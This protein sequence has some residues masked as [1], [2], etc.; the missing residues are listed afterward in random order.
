MSE[1]KTITSMSPEQQLN[2]MLVLAT[3]R[4]DGQ[5]D[6]GGWP[7]ILHC[8]KVM[9][10][11]RTRDFLLMSIAVGHD[12]FEDTDTTAEELRQ[13]GFDER[14]IRGIEALTKIPGQ[15]NREYLERVKANPDAIRVKL[16]DLRH[17]SDIRR[18]KGVTEKDLR[19]VEKY[20]KMYLE[21]VELVPALV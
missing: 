19:R 13:M 9:H 8:L 2:R 12:L 11:T 3:Q 10:Y 16:A 5:F 20:Q 15:T 21:L 4:H 7:Y 1:P 18:L 17:N 14:V 6:K